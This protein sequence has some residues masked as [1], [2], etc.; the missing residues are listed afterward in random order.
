MS[1]SWPKH[2]LKSHSWCSRGPPGGHLASRSDRIRKNMPAVDSKT[3]PVARSVLTTPLARRTPP[4]Q[5]RDRDLSSRGPC[6]HRT[7]KQAQTTQQ[8]QSI[9]KLFSTQIDKSNSGQ[10]V[11]ARNPPPPPAFD[12]W[13]PASHRQVAHAL[14]HSPEPGLTEPPLGLESPVRPGFGLRPN[15]GEKLGGTFLRIRLDIKDK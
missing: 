10:G 5:A 12:N 15:P 1:Q 14:G 8:T 13:P 7:F 11:R 4:T 6:Q 2:A 9:T 3:V